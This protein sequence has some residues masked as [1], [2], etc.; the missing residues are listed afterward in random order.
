MKRPCAF[1]FLL[2]AL[3]GCGS[4]GQELHGVYA[5][6]GTAHYSIQDIGHYSSQVSDT[7]RVSEGTVSELLLTDAAGRCF[8]LADVEGEAVVLRRGSS[9][10]YPGDNGLTLT[11]TLERGTLSL[12]G[13]SGRFDM[14]GTV[15]ATAWGRMYPGSFFQNATLTRVEP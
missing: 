2:L 10:T 8:L 14:A 5:V 6:T 15:T 4:A 11:V 3:L 7:F 1:P 13:G 12:S 9:C